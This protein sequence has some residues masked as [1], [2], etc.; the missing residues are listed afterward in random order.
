[1]EKSISGISRVIAF[2][3]RIRIKD[4][5]TST[6]ALCHSLSSGL[7][8]IQISA[9]AAAAMANSSTRSTSLIIHLT[10]SAEEETIRPPLDQPLHSMDGGEMR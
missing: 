10:D 2:G 7:W 6:H 5:G 8:S 4:K 3:M 1:M 9:L